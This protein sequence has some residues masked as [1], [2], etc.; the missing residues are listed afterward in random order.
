MFCKKHDFGNLQ[1]FD[2][3]EEFHGFRIFFIVVVV[4]DD[5]RR[6]TSVGEEYVQ[7]KNAG[8]LCSNSG[9]L[10]TFLE[11]VSK[12]KEKRSKCLKYFF[13][14]KMGAVGG[15]LLLHN[16]LLLTK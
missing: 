7:L 1:N 5:D 13:F 2:I 6:A 15:G 14:T 10:V 11:L 4:V 16:F 3:F 12:L 9:D 8:C